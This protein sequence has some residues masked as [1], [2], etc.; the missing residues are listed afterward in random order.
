MALGRACPPGG[1]WAAPLSGTG[2]GSPCWSLCPPEEEATALRPEFQPPTPRLMGKTPQLLP[3]TQLGASSA[4][5][6]PSQGGA[7][8]APS[9]RPCSSTTPVGLVGASLVPKQ[10][11]VSSRGTLS[12][13]AWTLHP[14]D[15]CATNILSKPH[16]R[17]PL[18][19]PRPTCPCFLGIM[20]ATSKSHFLN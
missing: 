16:P 5:T 4:P 10:A 2:T 18:P 6:L 8:R 1:P 19:Q 7:H 9:A 11:H 15:S 17:P 3:Q 12:M 14:Q 20:Q 13:M